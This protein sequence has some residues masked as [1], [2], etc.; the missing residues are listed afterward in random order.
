MMM[1][2]KEDLFTSICNTCGCIKWNI[3]SNL[4]FSFNGMDTICR[5]CYVCNIKC[6]YIFQRAEQVNHFL[7]QA[8]V[9]IFRTMS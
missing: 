6:S 4:I 1:Q 2:Q 8:R 9:I 3:E 5:G 7:M